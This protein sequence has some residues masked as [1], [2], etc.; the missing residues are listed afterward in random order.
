LKTSK[1]NNSASNLLRTL[2]YAYQNSRFYSNEKYKTVFENKLEGFEGLPFT[3]KEDLSQFNDDF[4][5]TP[6]GEVKEYV[7]TSGTIG[8]PVTFFLTE[9]DLGRLEENEKQSMITAGCS[10]NDVF[11]L[12]TTVDKRFMAGLAYILGVR[13]L[14]AGM[15]RVGPGTPFL[16]WDS[17]QRFKP[18]VL[19][20]IPSFIHNLIEYAKQNGIDYKN[21][22]VKK[23][24][25]IGEPIRQD[26]FSLN[27]IGNKIISDWEVELISTYA[28]TEMGAAFTECSSHNGGHLQEDLI[29]LEVVDESGKIVESGQSGEVVVTTLGVEG[30]P[31]LGPVLGRKEQMIKSKGTTIF[32]QSIINVM[33]N[34]PETKNFVIQVEKNDLE[35]DLVSIL[36]N[37]KLENQKEVLKKLD[38]KLSSIKFQENKRKPTIFMDLR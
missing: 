5:C 6:L 15:V 19:I 26:D 22:S 24:I 1:S 17:I 35:Q 33:N 34:F 7:T 13:K 23:I 11:Q 30:M 10:E 2:E 37:N 20:A 38:E 12:M 4:L 36:L 25:C 3:T 28:S 16:Q 14:G 31:L 32:P 18:T 8:E 21:S 9:K 27:Q 29:Y